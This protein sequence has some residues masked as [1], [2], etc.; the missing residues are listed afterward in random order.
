LIGTTYVV[1]EAW[2][3]VGHQYLGVVV[4]CSRPRDPVCCTGNEKRRRTCLDDTNDDDGLLQLSFPLF[5]CVK[6]IPLPCVVAGI[7]KVT[8]SIRIIIV[9]IAAPFCVGSA[10]PP[11]PPPPPF[12]PGPNFVSNEDAGNLPTTELENLLLL[13]PDLGTLGS[14][15][16]F[17]SLTS[18]AAIKAGQVAQDDV[19]SADPTLLVGTDTIDFNLFSGE[20]T[21]NFFVPGQLEF[22]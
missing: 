6:R 8:T 7:M 16:S 5:S 12:D 2:L 14:T 20:S 1:T 22:P 21:Q 17:G 13:N 9:A 10:P 3:A 15:G 19:A 4:L 18:S 11:P